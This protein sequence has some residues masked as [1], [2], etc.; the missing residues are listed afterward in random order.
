MVTKKNGLLMLVVCLFHFG[1]AQK[2]IYLTKGLLVNGVHRYGREALY[3]DTLAYSMYSNNLKAPVE[4]NKLAAGIKDGSTVWKQVEADSE[5]VFKTRSFG[6]GGY[7]YFNYPSKKAEVV[8]LNIKGNSAVYVNGILHAGDPYGSGWLYIPVQL[9]KGSNDLYVRTYFQTVVSIVYPEKKITISTAD[10]TMPHV[11]L[12]KQ[13]GV[14]KGALVIINASEKPLVNYQLKAAVNGKTIVSQVA[15]VPALGSRKIIFEFDAA[16][17][18]SVGSHNCELTLFNSNKTVDQ[19]KMIVEAV[20]ASN[21]FS[22]TFISGIDG[23]LQYFATTPQLNGSKPNEAL[24]LSVHGAGVEAIGQAKAYQ[25]K[26]WGTLVAATNRRPRGFNWEDWGR[27]DALEVLKIAKQTYKPDP[28][29]IYLTGHSMGGHGTWFLGATYPGTWAAIAPCSGYPT[30]KEYGSADGKIPAGSTIAAEQMLLRAG[31]Q[32]DV[33]NLAANYKPLGVYVLH[34][35]SDRVVSVKYARQMKNVLASFH[36]DYSYYEYP[37]GEHW[38]GDQS[39]DWKP[40]FEFFKWH[41]RLDDSLVNEIDFTTS[42]PGI[43]AEYR[44]AS[45]MQQMHPL[46]YSNLLLKRNS[47]TNTISGST[48]NVSV[49]KLA[50]PNISANT[51]VTILLDS[52]SAVHYTTAVANDTVYLTRKKANWEIS[53]KPGIQQKGPHNYGT[54]KEAFNHNMVFIYSTMGSKEENEAT[55][56][57]AKFDA[58]SWYY[59]GN[60]AVDIIADKMYDQDTYKG[61]NAIIYGNAATNAAWSMLLKGCPLQVERNKVTAGGKI[62]NGDDL[63]AYF[64]W[65]QA[66]G[67]HSTG[68]VAGTGL[69]GMQAANAN[70]YFAGGS[71]FPDFI[72][73]SLDM[74][75]SGASGVKTTGFFDNNWKLDLNESVQNN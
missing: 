38:F 73:F 58:E 12:E 36:P 72:I 27:M 13:N 43:S 63:A 8:L 15:E 47:K 66:D 6:G 10:S 71:G 69:K 20:T 42:S 75:V 67:I 32:S 11:V 62:Y 48:K 41:T 68:V 52:T 28:K 5:H 37:G 9:K 45:V 35:D 33:I 50:F 19:K 40:L 7:L 54:F 61:R 56:N 59:R 53:G 55:Y 30:L 34:G 23:S 31:N 64:V 26:D 21:K 25:S 46:Q 60:G 14:L 16:G 74:L 49:L 24:F 1:M 2:T 22:T 29:R 65:P 3:S 18:S 51:P 57:K 4:G 70:Q 17:I 44:W 39:V